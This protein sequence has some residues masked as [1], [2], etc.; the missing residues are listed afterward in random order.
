MVGLMLP[1]EQD[2][3]RGSAAAKTSE[4]ENRKHW[5]ELTRKDER[6]VARK[7]SRENSRIYRTHRNVRWLPLDDG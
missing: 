7:G 5:R 3:I 2:R 1:F 6:E 4:R